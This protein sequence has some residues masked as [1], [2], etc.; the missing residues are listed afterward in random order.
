MRKLKLYLESTI[1]SYYTA[2]PSRNVIDAG[3]QAITIDWW[4]SRIGYFDVYISQVVIDE[5]SYGDPLVSRKRL[6]VVQAFS[7]LDVDDKIA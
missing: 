7:I 5:I 2:R 1:P 3:R 4:D 6:D